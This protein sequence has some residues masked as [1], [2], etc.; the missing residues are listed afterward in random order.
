MAEAADPNFDEQRV[1]L[2]TQ[3]KEDGEDL[4]GQRNSNVPKMAPS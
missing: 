1:P 4:E 3:D 2:I